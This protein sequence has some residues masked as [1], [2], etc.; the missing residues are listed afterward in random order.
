MVSTEC[1]AA[2][3]C[4]DGH[5]PTGWLRDRELATERV[6]TLATGPVINNAGLH[7]SDQPLHLSDR[8]RPKPCTLATVTSYTNRVYKKSK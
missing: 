5:D 6:C 1:A 2:R 8:R 4:K 7:L 3:D